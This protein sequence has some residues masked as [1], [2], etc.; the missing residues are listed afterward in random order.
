[1]KR[2]ALSSKQP[3]R[4][5]FKVVSKLRKLIIPRLSLTVFVLAKRR[6]RDIDADRQITLIPLGTKLSADQIRY[7]FPYVHICEN[8]C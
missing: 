6:R 1:M 4:R 8:S 5:N 3:I 2:V 7:L